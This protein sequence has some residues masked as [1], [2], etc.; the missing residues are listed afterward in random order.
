MQQKQFIKTSLRLFLNE[1]NT[2]IK[3]NWFHGTPDA[4]EVEKEGGFTHRTITVEYIK[5]PLAFKELE[6]NM[7][8]ARQNGDEKL[9]FKLLDKISSFKETY[10]YN[11]PLFLSDNYSVAKTYADPNRA[12][13]YQNAKEKV[14]EVDVDCSKIVKIV[15]TG[16]RFRFIG[17]DKVKRGF[18]NAG[19]T[20]EVIDKLIMMFNFFDY[21]NNGMKTDNIGAIGSW[22]KFDCID[23]VGVLDSYRGGSTKSTIKM[24]LDPTKVTIKNNI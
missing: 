9:Y 18:I 4:R 23:I 19:V 3:E 1:Q 16:D 7:N 5:D 22:L 17:I 6:G 20:E 14:F 13:D 21:N 11:K 24:V 10:S 12:Y 8:M 15:A 2:Q